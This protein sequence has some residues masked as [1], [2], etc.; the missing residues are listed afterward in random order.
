MNIGLAGKVSS[1]PAKTIRY[2]EDIG[3]IHPARRENGYRD[4]SEEDVHKLS[5]LQRA[6]SLGFTIEDCR[7]L[8]SLYEDDTR[9]SK[10]VKAIARNHMEKID[11]KISE[12]KA[13][14]AT[15]HHLIEH[16]HG[17][18]RPDCPIIEGLSS[19]M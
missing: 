15:L 16:C 10:D 5:F 11:K 4:Y 3:L 9:A 12:L 13:M 19:D 6:R 18:D 17:D 7:V 8:L 1:L 14:Q 2:Y